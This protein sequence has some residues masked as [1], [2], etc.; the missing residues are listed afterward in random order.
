MKVYKLTLP[1]GIWYKAQ[2]TQEDHVL[3]DGRVSDVVGNALG[4]NK[5]IGQK[6]SVDMLGLQPL[7]PLSLI[8][9]TVVSSVCKLELLALLKHVLH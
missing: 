4:M 6:A 5:Y 9:L 1:I 3:C 8:L 7:D 2:L